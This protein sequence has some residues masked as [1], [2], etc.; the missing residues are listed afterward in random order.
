MD[1]G[2]PKIHRA[3]RHTVTDLVALVRFTFGQDNELVP[4][5][6]TVQERYEGWLLQQAQLGVSFT[7]RKRWWLDRIAD[8][9]AQSAG[10]DTDDLDNAPFIER[11][12]IDGALS[13]LGAEAGALVIQLTA[14]LTA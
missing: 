14:E 13:D 8:V 2:H 10:I 3:D 6:D 5:A 11:G 9:V 7:E 1:L 4:Y 12:G